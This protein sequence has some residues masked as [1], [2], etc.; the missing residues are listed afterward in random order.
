MLSGSQVSEFK[1]GLSCSRVVLREIRD[2][3]GIH[4]L[5]DMVTK[6]IGLTAL[7]GPISF[8]S[9]DFG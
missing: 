7:V 8:A 4:Q 1:K 6:D 9:T 5:C 3:S 2:S